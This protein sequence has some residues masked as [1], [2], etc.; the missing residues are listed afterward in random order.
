MTPTLRSRQ[1]SKIVDPL[2][3][4]SGPSKRQKAKQR[5]TDAPNSEEDNTDNN[6]NNSKQIPGEDIIDTKNQAVIDL[7]RLELRRLQ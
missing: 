2:T 6:E 3:R 7:Q 1:A 4:K 5:A